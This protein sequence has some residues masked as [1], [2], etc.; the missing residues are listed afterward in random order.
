MPTDTF[1]DRAR[2]DARDK[3]LGRTP[4]TADVHLPGLL[5]AM[6][7]PATIAHGKTLTVAIEA[8]I[9]VPGVVRVLTARDFAPP[10]A[11]PVDD[12]NVLAV[13]TMP[14]IVSE[15]AYRGA[16]IALVV[17]ESLEAAIQGAEAI[18][19]QY[20][21]SPSTP[22]ITSDGSVKEER[23]P[24]TAGDAQAEMKRAETVVAAEYES[25]AQHHN[26]ME[27]LATTAIWSGGRLTI[28]DATQGAQL[29]KVTVAR[30]LG[31]DPA[32]IDVKCGYVGG[33]FGQKSAAQRQSAIV[34]RA[35]MLLGRPVKLVMPRGQI[36]HTATFR[37]VSRHRIKIGADAAGKMIAVEYDADHQQS[38]TG[39]FPPDYH[40][41]QPQMYGIADYHG[42]SANIRIDT[43]DPGYMR[44][45]HPHPASFA[46]EG[47]VDEL[48]Y[49]LGKDPVAF[50]LAHDTMT[51]P[52][53]GHPLS[54]RFLN[55]CIAEGAE[56]FGWNK[57]RPEPGSTVL[58]DGTLVGFGVGCGAYPAITSANI[59]TLRIAADGTTRYAAAGH[60]MGQGIR[61]VIA[62]ILLR[63]LAINPDK[64]D[65]V[66][67]DTTAVPQHVTAGSWGTA[68]AI[69]VAEAAAAKMKATLAE[70]LADRQISGNLHQQLARVRRPYLQ[71]E[72]S[73]L[74]PG[75]DSK[76]FQQMRDTGFAAAG[77]AYPRFTSFSYIAHFA[78][79][80]FNPRTGRVWVPR[81]VSVADC[82]RVIS[83]RTATSQVR[84]GVIW[85]IG[86][87]LR[88]ETDVDP[89]FG[90]WLNN[91]LADYP[92][93][94]QSDIGDIDV[95]LLDRPDPIL[96]AT[97]AKGLGEVAM[98]GAAGAVG[99]GLFHATGKRLR[100]MP[101][102]L[103]NMVPRV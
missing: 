81:V 56:R 50:R 51:D 40:E 62:A 5:F 70:L 35:A 71:I 17:A 19:A 59:A 13:A 27:L 89:R 29:V 60:E 1:L 4:F 24:V 83:P 42:T 55:E 91:S 86:A 3:V 96:N 76:A 102:R 99:N 85:A 36:F 21:E 7:V 74:A 30:A 22:L 26:P 8:A 33:G 20:A 45:P 84:G 28:Y 41:S 18:R 97:G 101:I 94:V 69:P 14:T 67:G 6:T 23:E 90:G 44:A 95:L 52:L 15:I 75:Q 53:T 9:Q 98:V 47:A 82:G 58:P 87:A 66:L 68:S 78:E 16:P 11:A 25:P 43:Q 48:A 10:V 63:E 32:I 92:V 2:F 38:R 61:N 31:L 49:K 57:R 100:K 73:S 72:V 37:P 79:V 64:I 39:R 77:P 12:K 103:E 80:R 88:E 34:A 93:P 54:S 65:I 46:F